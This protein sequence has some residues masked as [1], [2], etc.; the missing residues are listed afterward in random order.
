[1]E[2]LAPGYTFETNSLRTPL[3][4]FIADEAAEAVADA[5]S[6]L[7]K[8]TATRGLM[9]IPTNEADEY[10][11][12]QETRDTARALLNN[13]KPLL[14]WEYGLKV[15]E[16]IQAAY[17]AAE[18]KKTIDLTDPNIKKELKNYEPLVAQGRGSEI[19]YS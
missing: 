2:G 11:Y 17:M 14:D 7:E 8:A 19:L 3:E 9:A 5:E 1:M 12:V 15:T 18:K 6:A 16:L 13:Q 4:I 10:G